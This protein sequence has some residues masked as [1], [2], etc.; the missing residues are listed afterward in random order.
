MVHLTQQ[1]RAAIDAVARQFLATWEE[2]RDAPGAVITAAGKRIAVDVATLKGRGA[3]PANAAQP[4]LRFDKVVVRLMQRLQATLGRTVPEGVTVALTITA[5][6]RLASK[7]AAAL[8][9]KIPARFEQGPARRI[10]PDV[11]AII[12]GN[13]VRIRFFINK[14]ARAPKV[15]GFVHNPDTDPVPLLNLTGEMLQ[16]ASAMTARQMPGDSGDLWLVVISAERFS[17][18]EACRSIC[19]QLGMAAGFGKILMVFGDG[20][21]GILAE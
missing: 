20:R 16:L 19:S 3:R 7:T 17:Y 11:K 1:E 13:R 14:S 8:E 5:P 18:L 15:I 2:D 9:E 4:R 6:I 12:H 10:R 21:V